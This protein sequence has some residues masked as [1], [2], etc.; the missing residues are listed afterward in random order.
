VVVFHDEDMERLTGVKKNIT[1]LTWDEISQLKYKKVVDVTGNGQMREYESEQPISLLEDVLNEFKGKD[2]ILDV[3]LK[4]YKPMYSRRHVGTETAKVIRA[5][6][7]ASQL[8]VTSFDFFMLHTLENEYPGLESGFAYDDGFAASLGQSNTWFEMT[9]EIAAEKHLQP[10]NDESFLH[11]IIEANIVGKIIGSTVVNLE[12]TLLDD[13]T[14]QKFH[15]KGMAVG[16]YTLYAEDLRT[17]KKPLNEEQY[18]NLISNL[19]VQRVD[20]I[21]TDD[22]P[23][24]IKDLENLKKKHPEKVDSTKPKQEKTIEKKDNKCKCI[25]C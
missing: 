3:E 8:V 9:P 2:F 16:T 22:A 17:V 6:G 21:E 19:F 15:K 20:W 14:V 7:T 4:A 23:R 5:T 12:Y 10:H 1:E 11:F 24:L 25:V 18:L 13:D